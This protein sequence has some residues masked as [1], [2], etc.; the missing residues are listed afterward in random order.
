MMTSRAT[1][2]LLMTCVLVLASMAF[3]QTQA[4]A[5]GANAALKSPDAVLFGRAIQ[6]TENSHYAEARILLVKLIRSYPNSDYV[7]RAKV[8]IGDAWY[9]EGV[10]QRALMEYQD[11]ITFFPNR[12]EVMEAR[13]KIDAI[14]KKTE[15]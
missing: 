12:P 13:Q 8:S 7:P 3:C 15:M 11:F 2:F 4:T 9:A 1:S 14:Q 6:A 10:F 5:P